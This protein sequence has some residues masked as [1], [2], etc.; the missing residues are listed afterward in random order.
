MPKQKL[1]SVSDF[2]HSRLHSPRSIRVLNLRP[3]EDL[4]DPVEVSLFEVTLDELHSKQQSYEALSYVWGAPTGS[5]PCLCDGKE[6][7][8][9]PSCDDALRHLRLPDEHRNLWVDAI[10]IDQASDED[11]IEERNTQITLM[12]EVYRTAKRT[13]CW[14]G[15]SEEYTAGTFE[16]LRQM[17]SCSSNRELKKLLRYDGTERLPRSHIDTELF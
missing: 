14:F 12:G 6:L 10:C 17:G 16:R 7:L 13:L 9:T 4:S 1:V 2:Q 8:I 5:V 15:I 3:S 11:S